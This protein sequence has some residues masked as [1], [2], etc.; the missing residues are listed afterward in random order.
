M[1]DTKLNLITDELEWV[2]SLVESEQADRESGDD[3]HSA[4]ELGF[5]AEKLRKALREKLH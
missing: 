1:A 3:H 5:I 4:G 2:I